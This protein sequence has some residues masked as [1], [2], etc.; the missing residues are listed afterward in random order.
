MLDSTQVSHSAVLAGNVDDQD[1]RAGV[2]DDV[3]WDEENF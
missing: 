2:A 1:R 3:V